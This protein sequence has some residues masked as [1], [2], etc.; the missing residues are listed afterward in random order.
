MEVRGNGGAA[1]LHGNPDVLRR[2]SIGVISDTH[3]LLR[4]SA[5]VALFGSDFIIHAGDIGSP[6]ILERLS[7]IAPVVAVRG[8]TDQG[9]WLGGVPA[10][11]VIDVGGCLIYMLHN[12]HVLDLDPV[13]AGISVVISG[14]THQP[15]QY[16][17]DG[18]MYLNPGSCGPKRFKCPVSLARL[19]IVKGVPEAELIELPE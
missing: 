12:L 16:E 3:G 7:G 1:I 6:E 8:N 17:K 14:H 18:V 5:V 9:D 10:N 2:V 19:R 13:A 11:E 15:A 4:P